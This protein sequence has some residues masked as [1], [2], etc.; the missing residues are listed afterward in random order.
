MGAAGGDYYYLY[1][2]PE[3]WTRPTFG[4]GCS[5]GINEAGA[6]SKDM[7]IRAST[8]ADRAMVEPMSVAG[9][10]FL[11]RMFGSAL[12]RGIRTDEINGL[13]GKLRKAEIS[14]NFIVKTKE[15]K[16]R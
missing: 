11:K 13:M 10:N 7:I 9:M 12:R 5:I 1:W 8:S 4:F 14:F 6:M 16:A 2:N 15:Q 3:I